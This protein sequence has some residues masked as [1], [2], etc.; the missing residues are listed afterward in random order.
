VEEFSE[1]AY[2]HLLSLQK[3]LEPFREG[4]LTELFRSP[5]GLDRVRTAL[6]E[7]AAPDLVTVMVGSEQGFS[8]TFEGVEG[9]IEGWRDF[10]DAFASFNN[11][12]ER[13]IEVDPD[14]ILAPSRQRATTATGGV[15]M[16][17][18]AAALFR[19][20]DGRLRR[21]EFHLDSESAAH[22]V[23]LD[24]DRMRE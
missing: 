1:S 7:I 6:G 24:P 18:R 19:F 15:E 21:A 16:D 20:K 22:A 4:D 14:T 9:F 11:E 5:E 17:N 13:F 10:L 23:G 3:A 12:V 2:A 8:G